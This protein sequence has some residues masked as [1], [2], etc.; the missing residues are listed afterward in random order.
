MPIHR[1]LRATDA[2]AATTAGARAV[3]AAGLAV[4]ACL[5]AHAQARDVPDLTELSLE[6]LLDLKIVGASKYA[7]AQ[8]EVAAAVSVITRRDIR[9]FGWRT[10]DEAL[11]S[12]P[13]VHTTESRQITALGARGFGLPGDFNTRVLVM[14]NGHRVNEPIYD[15][16]VA[17]QGFPLDLDL[18]Q[19]IEF[20]PGPGGAVYGQNAM[21]GVVNVI[22]RTPAD[23]DGAEI[24]VGYQDPQAAREGRLSWGRS[25]DNGLGA[26]VSLSGMNADG[27]DLYLDYGDA[28]VSGLAAGMDGE[29]TRRVYARAEYGAWSIEHAYGSWFKE[30]PTGT[31]FSDPLSPGQYIESKLAMTQLQY[32]ESFAGER[33]VVSARLFRRTLQYRTLLHFSGTPYASD[34]QSRL[35][36]GEL[37]L[38]YTGLDNHKLML[39]IEGQQSPRSEQVIPVSGDP[40]DN[41]LISSPGHRLGV[42][43]QDEWRLTDSLTATLGLRIDEND[44]TG[45][46]ASPRTGLIWQATPA[47]ALKAL[48]GRAHRAPNAYERDYDDGA[49]LVGNPNLRGEHIDTFELVADH[50]LGETTTLRASLYQWDM[51]HLIVLGLQPDSGLPQYQ[52]GGNIRARGAE[53]SM[54]RT[55]KPGVRLRSSLSLQDVSW[56]SGGDLVNSPNLLG[57]INLSGLLPWGGI[58]ASY[59]LRH[60]ARRLTHDGTWLGGY[61]LSNVSLSRSVRQKGLEASLSVY[62]LFNKHYETPGA[63]SHWQNAFEQDGRAVR[64]RLGYQF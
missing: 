7:Q 28:G 37:R 49:T 20:V 48:Y 38:V 19:R 30:D 26:M 62:N 2:P 8:G 22:T 40:A 11:A 64:F 10:L 15:S 18:V 9:A 41:L 24:S 23:L 47:T 51:K 34:T 16:G 39:G 50:R 29:K 43:G 6:Q 13:G 12:L 32:E 4:A 61:T 54:N 33:L 25:F 57:R 35:H 60:D 59:E 58:R 55:W 56:G 14:I 42:Y 44:M 53:L 45:T 46:H 52:S 63:T 1:R 17:G 21:F 3:L 36:G 31:F 27:E 5:P